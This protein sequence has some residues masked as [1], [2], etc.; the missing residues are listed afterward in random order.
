MGSINSALSIVNSALDADQEALNVVANNVA[1]ANTPGYAREVPTWQENSPI[2]INSSSFGSGVCQTG[3]A[4]MRDRVLEQRIVQQQQMSAASSARST[5]LQSVQ[6]LFT[7]SSGSS[8]SGAG[9]IGVDLTEFFS[10]LSS[11]E[12]DSGNNALRQQVLSTATTLAGDVSTAASSLNAQR[13]SLDQQVAGSIPEVNSLT[14]AIA[15]LNQQIQ[16]TESK[17]D[18]GVLEDQRRQYIDQLS[19]II[20]INEVTTE[21]NGLSLTTVS[22]D[23]LVSESTSFQL[24]SGI[25]NGE[26]HIFVDS[27]DITMQLASGG[28]SLGGIMTVRDTDIPNVLNSLDQLAYSVSTSVNQQN[29]AGVDLAGD[30]GN[31]GDIFSNSA[32]VAGSAFGMSVVMADPNHIAAG[33]P[34]AGTGDNSNAS[35]MAALATQSFING[36][37][38]SNYYSQFVSTLGSMVSEVD[39][40]NEAQNSSLTQLQTQRNALSGVNLNDEAASMQQFERSYQAASQVFSILNSIMSCALNLGVQTAVS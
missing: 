27:K 14:S 21:G 38:P 18:A 11:L 23:L 19:K 17:T 35:A 2:E 3:P 10:S 7:P 13:N 9:N 8:D 29:N 22:G 1:N 37:T 28:G 5:A 20:G 4:S 39:I 31:A 32:Q 30:Q 6:A 16:A 33:S 34:G 26:T 12:A 24:R 40:E 25:A 15:Q 36:S